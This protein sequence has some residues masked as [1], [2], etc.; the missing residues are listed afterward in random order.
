MSAYLKASIKRSYAE[1]FLSELERNNNQ[2]FLFI[3]RSVPWTDENAPPTAGTTN[4]PDSDANEYEIMRG[5]V[6]Y[7]KLDPSGILF[8][9]P[10]YAWTSGTVY[11]Q[12]D[13]TVSLFDDSDPQIFY[14]VTDE[15]N[16][17]KCL[18][19]AAGTRSTIKPYGTSIVAVT[20][21]DGYVWKYMATVRPSD[22]PYELSDYIPVDYITNSSDT[23]STNQYNVQ[24]TAVSGALTRVNFVTNGGASAA[25]Y[26]A[27]Q[28]SNNTNQLL[29]AQTTSGYAVSSAGVKTVTLDINSKLTT[30]SSAVG[31][32][33]QIASSEAAQTQNNYAL[34]TN[35]VN[36]TSNLTVFTVIDDATVF[37]PENLKNTKFNIIPRIRI[38]G[39]GSG[40]YAFPT[41]NSTKNITGINLIN[42]GQNYT[43]AS[44]SVTTSISTQPTKIHPSF[45]AVTSPKGG[46]GGNILKEL[47]VQD[48]IIIIKVNEEDVS[49]LRTG[50]SYRQFG[51]IKNPILNDPSGAVA[52]SDRPY[53]KDITFAYEGTNTSRGIADWR[54]NGF[55]GGSNNFIIGTESGVGSTVY[56][57]KSVG[58]RSLVVKAKIT[59]GNYVTQQNR[60]ND[61]ILTMQN[62]TEAGNY[63]LGEDLIQTVSAGSVDLI[64]GISYGYDL[65]A[66]GYLISKNDAKLIVRATQNSFAV[67]AKLSG[68]ISGATGTPSQVAPLLGEYAWIYDPTRQQFV[69]EEDNRNLFKVT[70]M[71][72]PYFD[73]NETPAYTGLTCLVL[74]TSVS[75]STG[76]IDTTSTALTPNSF[77]NGD[78]VQQGISASETGNY[79]SATVYSWEFT[80]ASTGRLFVTNTF[81]TFQSV[82]KN[83]TSGTTLGGYVVTN[84]I[85]PDIVPNSGEVIYINNIRSISR[86]I[87]QSEEFRLR[88]GF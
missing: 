33:L 83:G 46:H 45:T 15:N 17:Y 67:A 16:I 25:V 19:R 4:Y 55:P 21:S 70:Q 88:L 80:N 10:R 53:Y 6:G 59:G 30:P 84:V 69:T 43:Q 26:S 76:G 49:K 58:T 41:L 87:G 78:F 9:L 75:G 86:V 23:E 20:L 73:L 74:G 62:T 63:A 60:P 24:S 52:G 81:G 34:I 51:I 48:L 56:A 61:F 36:N 65:T 44:V 7:K 37:S 57:L 1:G 64:T 22:L 71:G 11:D 5:I 82:A 42:S 47:G 39:D 12:Y 68:V 40:A 29:M 79:A 3:A 35:G 28:Y 38:R 18:R 66:K 13:D 27:T 72:S 85:S 14:V 31:Y 77:S 8:A 2:Y 32:V 54:L 50:G